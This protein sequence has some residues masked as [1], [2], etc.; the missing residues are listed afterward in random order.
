MYPQLSKT[1]G[2]EELGL[3]TPIRVG[4]MH[5]QLPKMD[6]HKARDKYWGSQLQSAEETKTEGADFASIYY[7]QS[8]LG[9][10]NHCISD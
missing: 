7:H 4:P 8:R 2:G 5:P 9:W 1:G 6:P 3:P 10:G